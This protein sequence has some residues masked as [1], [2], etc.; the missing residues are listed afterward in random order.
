MRLHLRRALELLALFGKR[1]PAEL[2]QLAFALQEA[3]QSD[4]VEPSE[5]RQLLS[6]AGKRLRSVQPTLEPGL[7]VDTE[8]YVQARCAQNPESC[9]AGEGRRKILAENPEL[10]RR[11]LEA[12]T[13]AGLEA[14]MTPRLLALVEAQLEGELVWREV[15][16]ERI[17]SRLGKLG[18][19]TTS[20][21]T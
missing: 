1:A 16:L 20:M 6:I 10:L 12:L 21:F 14:K 9:F 8:V 5:T 18:F 15:A 19:R 3:A 2:R 11:A 13:Q 17:A 7:V 4:A